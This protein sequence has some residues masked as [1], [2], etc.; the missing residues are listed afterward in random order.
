MS[1]A[2]RTLFDVKRVFSAVNE[3]QTETRKRFYKKEELDF[4]SSVLELKKVMAE[5]SLHVYGCNS[6]EGRKLI[7]D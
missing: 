5:A 7:D 1:V 2:I 3:T 6:S 4:S